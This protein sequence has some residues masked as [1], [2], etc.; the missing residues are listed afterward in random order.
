[1][2]NSQHLSI[3]YRVINDLVVAK[4]NPRT[5]SPAQ[6]EQIARSIAAFGWTNPILIDET[7]SIIAGHGRL[8][9]ARKLGIAEVPTIT[10]AGLDAEQKRALVIADNQLALNAGWDSELLALELGELAAAGFDVSL[11]GF[12]DDEM[13]AILG[14]PLDGIGEGNG[15][16]SLAAQFGIP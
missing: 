14:E 6:I 7:S 13:A 10:L 15:A 12:S 9:A 5:H 16:G 3:T 8:D 1:M 11:I 2:R 4:R